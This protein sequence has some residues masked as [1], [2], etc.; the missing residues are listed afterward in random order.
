MDRK[1]KIFLSGAVFFTVVVLLFVFR[2]QIG[3]DFVFTSQLKGIFQELFSRE[4]PDR[5]IWLNDSSSSSSG[6]FLTKEN[7]SVSPKEKLLTIKY[8]SFS[9]ISKSLAGSAAINEIAW[10]GNVAN[11]NAEWLEL[12]NISGSQLSLV[13]YQLIDKAEQIKFIFSKDVILPAGGFYVLARENQGINAEAFYSGAL[14]NNNEGLRLFDKDCNLIDSVL[15][16]KEWPGG[17]NESKK[18]MERDAAGL[19]QTSLIVG[20]TSGRENS[21]PTVL[22]A[23]IVKEESKSDPAPVLESNQSEAPIVSNNQ[24]ISEPAPERPPVEQVQQPQPQQSVVLKP[25]LVSEIMVGKDGDANYE[26]IELYN[27]NNSAFSLTGWSLKKK[28]SNSNESALVTA[29]RL[30][31]RSVPARGYF[32]LANEEGYFG[33]PAA[34]IG[35]PKSYTLAYTNNFVVIYNADGQRV[36]EIGWSEILKDKSYERRSANSGDFFIQNS[37]NPQNSH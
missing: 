7:S 22:P 8:C 35:W 14:S 30:E 2:G 20:G 1:R 9:Q 36:E 10:M 32:L 28:N 15:A 23:L 18:T 25:I 4:K 17:D 21:E 24:I 37:P 13:G 6:Y 11:S 26:F 12:K 31:G 16:E 33:S 34:D 29:G 5:V 27:P 19:W 3:G